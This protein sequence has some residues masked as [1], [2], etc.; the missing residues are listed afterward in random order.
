MSNRITEAQ[1]EIA[2]EA[3]EKEG[4]MVKAAQAASVN[5]RTLQREAKRSALFRKQLDEADLLYHEYLKQLIREA[6]HNPN[7]KMPQLMAIFFEVKKH[8]PEYRDKLEHTVDG[9]IKIISGVPRPE[10]K[11]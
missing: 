10:T 11:N 7:I 9:G 4:N 2:I 3:Y 5:V 6:I 8:I 1:K